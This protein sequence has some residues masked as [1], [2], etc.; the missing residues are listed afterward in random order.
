MASV[1][2]EFDDEKQAT[3]LATLAEDGDLQELINER[4]SDLDDP[5]I[6]LVDVSNVSFNQ[7]G[8]GRHNVEMTSIES[9]DNEEEEEEDL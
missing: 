5:S 7:N 2:I 4:I 1:T 8:K 6:P 3:I 9:E